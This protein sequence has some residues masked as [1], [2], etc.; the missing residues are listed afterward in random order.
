MSQM[1]ILKNYKKVMAIP[2]NKTELVPAI[3]TSY[4]KLKNEL[5]DI[6]YD[7]FAKKF[8]YYPDDNTPLT[9]DHIGM[10][11]RGEIQWKKEQ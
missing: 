8:E 6:P 9:K 11:E 7:Q 1:P 2:T 5:V 10:I 3:K 4:Q